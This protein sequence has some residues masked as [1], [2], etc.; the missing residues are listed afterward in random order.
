MLKGIR[1][2][3]V[4]LGTA[5]VGWPLLGADPSYVSFDPGSRTWRIGNAFVERAIRLDGGGHFLTAAFLDKR[6]GR[7]WTP[8]GTNSGE[9]RVV[10]E[11][12][13]GTGAPGP[14][15]RTGLSTWTF[16]SENESVEEDGTADL[17]VRLLDAPD[18]VAI[19]VHYRCFPEAAA[20]RTWID[21]SNEGP[22]R[23]RLTAADAYRLQ[24]M[25]D[26]TEPELFW[27][28]N[29]T[30]SHPDSAFLTQ[31]DSLAPG[32]KPTL[33]TRRFGDTPIV[34]PASGEKSAFSTGP[35]GDGAAWF[36]LHGAGRGSG[37]YGGWEWSGTGTFSF[38]AAPATQGLVSLGVGFAEGH[39]SRVLENGET[40]SAPAGFV[41][42][43][44]GGWDGAARATRQLVERRYAPSLPDP[45]FP[46]VGFDTWGYGLAVDQGLVGR[47]I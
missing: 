8:P 46:W 30:W 21:V 23:V 29:F 15:I 19:T 7:N 27:V 22:E 31:V 25:G 17:D 34:V 16:L 24:I 4:L 10:F 36:A 2:L 12:G 18:R 26:G 45:T 32:E 11:R 14:V 6:T 3:L 42:L 43:F 41:G 33:S 37:L 40:F 47:L 39:F 38:E 1:L 5:S 13:D 9:F 35:F 44:S 20:I 28:P